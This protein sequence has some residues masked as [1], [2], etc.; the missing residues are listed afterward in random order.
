MS[1]TNK[2]KEDSGKPASDAPKT[3]RPKDKSG[4]VG[5]AL[6][7][8]YDDTVREQVPQDFLDLLGKLD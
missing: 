2:A 7:T 3:K 6:R 1:A 8:V 4:T 5:R